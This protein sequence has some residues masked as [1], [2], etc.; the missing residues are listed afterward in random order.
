MTDP[1]YGMA[2]L[3]RRFGAAPMGGGMAQ[4]RYRM[5]QASAPMRM[6]DGAAPVRQPSE[7][8]MAKFHRPHLPPSVLWRRHLC[9][10][11]ASGCRF[12]A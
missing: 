5:E 1:P 3:G 12:S 9:G 11:S 6:F 8:W 7:I 2:T 10:T 4:A